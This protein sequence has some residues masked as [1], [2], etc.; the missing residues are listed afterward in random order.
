MQ[1][2]VEGINHIDKEKLDSLVDMYLHKKI[3]HKTLIDCI[4]EAQKKLIINSISRP[5]DGNVSGEIL[6]RRMEQ[7]GIK[8]VI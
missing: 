8:I 5:Q 4:I 3:D 1:L 6:F 2:V 7:A